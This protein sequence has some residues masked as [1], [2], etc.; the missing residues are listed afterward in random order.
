MFAK[1]SVPYTWESSNGQGLASP[2][3][4]SLYKAD[5]TKRIEVARY[6]SPSG[7]FEVGGVMVVEER[8]VDVLVAV[9]TVLSVLGQRDSFR[10]PK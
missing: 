2:R 1:D 10:W 3:D 6:A 4:K 5:S 8:E 9:L 7:R